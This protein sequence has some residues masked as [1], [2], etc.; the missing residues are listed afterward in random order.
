MNRRLRD[1]WFT[2]KHTRADWRKLPGSGLRFL[3]GPE[4]DPITWRKILAQPGWMLVFIRYEK[5]N[6]E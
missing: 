2:V 6:Q 5:R 4:E 3:I 1:A